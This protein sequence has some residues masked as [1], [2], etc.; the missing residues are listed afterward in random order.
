MN[1]AAVATSFGD[2]ATAC[3]RRAEDD[4]AAGAVAA[5]STVC[6]FSAGICNRGVDFYALI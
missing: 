5:L 4:S 2:A 1:A 6:A 3:D